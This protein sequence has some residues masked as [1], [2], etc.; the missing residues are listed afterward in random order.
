MAF[1]ERSQSQNRNDLLF[2][3]GAIIFRPK[4]EGGV[5]ISVQATAFGMTETL[6]NVDTN[7]STG[8]T[9]DV[10]NVGM[11]MA[12]SASLMSFPSE[13]LHLITNGTKTDIAAGVASVQIISTDLSMSTSIIIT[14]LAGGIPAD[15]YGVWDIE[16]SN[17]E[18][19]STATAV[20]RVGS[21]NLGTTTTGNVGGIADL[22]IILTVPENSAVVAGDS[23][24]IAIL[25]AISGGVEIVGGGSPNTGHFSI[26]YAPDQSGSVEAG[27]TIEAV[28]IFDATL[29]GDVAMTNTT[30]EGRATE[31]TF[32]C[33]YDAEQGGYY[34]LIRAN[35]T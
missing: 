35:R 4:Y 17:S 15:A 1:T 30:I 12:A 2:G 5:G 16:F 26:L 29:T 32:T 11:T 33:A 18:F 6:T 24:R 14:E 27:S 20:A 9:S 13:L 21:P 22:G 28:E 23:L 10:R 8:V 3:T 31:L 25:P 7:L 34:K 19:D